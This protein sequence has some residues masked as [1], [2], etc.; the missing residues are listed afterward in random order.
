MGRRR[1]D[2]STC[3]V[4]TNQFKDK[5]PAGCDDIQPAFQLSYSGSLEFGLAV[6]EILHVNVCTEPGVVGEIPTHVIGIF[7]N[8]DWVGVPEPVIA[9]ANVVGGNAKIEA[10]EPEAIRAASGQPP[11]MVAAKAASEVSV[12]PG[13]IEMIVNIVRAGVMPNPLVV[14]MDVGSLRMSFFVREAG[15]L[16]GCS[17]VTSSRGWTVRGNV[18]ATDSMSATAMAALFLRNRQE[19]A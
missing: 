15:V 1:V 4:L 17:M 2:D 11:N 16:R 13:M 19:G 10:V 3:K 6:S 7:V 12:L 8:H 5:K 18:S 14:G 9:V